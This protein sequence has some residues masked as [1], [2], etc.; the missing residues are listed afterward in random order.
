MRKKKNIEEMEK[1]SLWRR[2]FFVIGLGLGSFLFMRQVWGSYQAIRQQE[3]IHLQSVYLVGG[4]ILSFLV[5]LLQMLAWITIMRCL[6]VPLGVHQTLQGYFLSFLP[7]YIP[8]SVWGYLSRGQWLEQSYGVEHSISALG[9]IL[10]ALALVSTAFVMAGVYLCLHSSGLMQ[11]LLALGC[12][13]LFT[14]TWLFMPKFVMRMSER[15]SLSYY[16]KGF[17]S[18]NW[19]MALI[20]YL[21]LWLSYG[22]SILLVGNAMMNT[23]SNDL[24]ATTFASTL[25]WALGFV[26]IFIPAGIGI[27]ELTLSTLLSLCVGYSA[28]QADL[29]AVTFRL[30][31][32]LAELGWLSVG[33][34]FRIRERW[35]A[36]S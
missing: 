26:A 33:L 32:L 9:S 35:K 25:S 14:A 36:A 31:V 13:S 17:S 1:A 23:P 6:N 19:A 21:P 2:V 34:L 12:T 22:G 3:V 16:G 15:K 30:E 8:G 10:E 20:L 18:W 5:Y 4:L 11:V 28:S 7:R 27:R 29:M 24:L